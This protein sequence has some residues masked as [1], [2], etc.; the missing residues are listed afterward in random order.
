MYWISDVIANTS[1][2]RWF[3]LGVILVVVFLAFNRRSRR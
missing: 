3:V 2:E 1:S